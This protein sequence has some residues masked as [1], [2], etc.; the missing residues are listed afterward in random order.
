M[1]LIQSFYHSERDSQ[2]RDKFFA[3]PQIHANYLYFLWILY[4]YG[5]PSHRTTPAKAVAICITVAST[6]VLSISL[7]S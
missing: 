4:S 6:E 2:A 5:Y 1:A 3:E 7:S